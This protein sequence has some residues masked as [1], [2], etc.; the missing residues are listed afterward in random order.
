MC[1]SKDYFNS[2]TAETAG[3]VFFLSMYVQN[4]FFPIREDV[5]KKIFSNDGSAGDAL[6]VNKCEFEYYLYVNEESWARSRGD[7]DFQLNIIYK[8]IKVRI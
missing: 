8:I 2:R 4:T 6:R 3:D 5:G 1:A 7:I